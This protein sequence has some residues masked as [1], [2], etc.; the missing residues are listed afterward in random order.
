M[1]RSRSQAPVRAFP[2][3]RPPVCAALRQGSR[4]CTGRSPPPPALLSSSLSVAILAQLVS[5]RTRAPVLVTL[6]AMNAYHPPLPVWC[7]GPRAMFTWQSESQYWYCVACNRYA[8]RE[9]CQGAKHQKQ[10]AWF[11][12]LPE[13]SCSGSR[14]CQ[15]GALEPWVTKHRDEATMSDYYYCWPIQRCFSTYPPSWF[16]KW[17][18]EVQRSGYLTPATIVSVC[19][20]PVMSDQEPPP[21][22]ATFGCSARRPTFA[23][24]LRFFGPSVYQKLRQRAAEVA[25]RHEGVA[26]YAAPSSLCAVAYTDCDKSSIVRPLCR[27]DWGL[28]WPILAVCTPSSGWETW[29]IAAAEAGWANGWSTHGSRLHIYVQKKHDPSP[30]PFAHSTVKIEE[31][32]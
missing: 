27:E 25:A 9:H 29:C 31:L 26:K 10:V 16:K 14:T 21:L 6:S 17:V 24:A 8:T 20:G 23:D 4:A 19:G 7:E 28:W 22:V 30:D 11:P 13:D 1:V 32:D 18:E 3:P 15:P 5:L 2:G 12:A